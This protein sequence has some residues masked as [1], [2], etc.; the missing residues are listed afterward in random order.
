MGMTLS[1]LAELRHT[2]GILLA[3]KIVRRIPFRPID[4]G[5]LCFL[6][7][8]RIPRVPPGLLRGPGSVRLA[9]LDDLD[10]LVLLRDQREVFLA[11]FSE[12]DRCVVAEVGGRIAGYEWFCDRDVHEE[13]AW[14]YRIDI[15]PGFLYAY[16]AFID[17]RYRNSGIWLRFKAHLGHLMMESG[18][19]GVLTFIDYG[20]WPSLRTHLRFGFR[21]VSEVF[22]LRILGKLVSRAF[23]VV[24][25]SGPSALGERVPGPL[26][27]DAS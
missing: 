27:P 11:R 12:G 16:D 14:G 9:T 10:A 13:T 8:D 15:P 22:V 7:L 5:R 19:S 1:R 17:P 24:L 25:A 21:P 23:L 4:V 3:Q 26:N 20:N 2:P 6:R 18:H